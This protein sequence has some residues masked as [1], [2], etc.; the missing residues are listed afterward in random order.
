MAE[1]IVGT[2]IGVAGLVVGFKGALDGF[3]LLAD[4]FASDT[5]LIFASLQY[6]VEMIK[7]QQWGQRLNMEDATNSLL[8]GESRTVQDIVGQIIVEIL[9]IQEMAGQAFVEKY[10]MAG[11]KTVSGQHMSSFQDKT[12]WI[13]HIK[14]ERAKLKQGRRVCWVARDQVK[15]TGLLSRLSKLNQDLESLV[16]PTEYNEAR[17]VAAILNGVDKRLSLAPLQQTEGSPGTLLSL[18][19]LL[20]KVQE[21]D[22]RVAANR[23]HH[24]DPS[25]LT[26]FSD[27]SA[28][29]GRCLGSYD[30]PGQLPEQVLLEWKGIEA[31]N[32]SKGEIVTR[33]QALGAVLAT[34]NSP[35]FHRLSCIG[36]FDD[37][38]YEQRSKGGRRIALVYSLPRALGDKGP[39]S[40]LDLIK[41]AKDNR[42]RPALGERFELAY[43]LASAVSLFHAAN[44]LH[45]SF[46]SDSVLFASNHAITD[47]YI[48]GFQYS[49]PATATSIE[50]RPLE[51][52]ELGL[53][54]HPDVC[55][56][57]T[58]IREIYSLG[59]VLLEVAFWR[60]VFEKRFRDM[61][62][63][64]VSEAI[65]KDL[66]GKFGDD[67]TGMV[68]KMFVDVVKCCLN[69]Y[70]AFGD[71]MGSSQQESEVLGKKFFHH[72]VMPLSSIKA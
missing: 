58:K 43:K 20:K 7:F 50:S 14:G 67:L 8:K 70:E 39:P 15:L 9:A 29:T 17:V 21:E 27:P 19:A 49:R 6:N 46:R 69:G 45:K 5:G 33:I 55:K 61:T 32:T 53:Y 64:Q 72:V 68:G 44:W 1:F 31:N 38:E 37:A 54:Y 25:S 65:S 47:P 63:D 26:F 40:L 13:A 22:V 42:T 35:Q 57:W 3:N 34:P 56:G 52:P 62:A 66:D 41:S 24:I 59:I 60:P 28:V 4:M 11:I 12:K 51:V 36:V 10:K 16:R 48:A 2:T 30:T 71:G 23:V 18:S